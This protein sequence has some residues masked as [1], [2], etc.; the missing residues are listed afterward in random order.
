VCVEAGQADL[1]LSGYLG[2]DFQTR[3][4]AVYRLLDAV[5][6]FHRGLP[7]VGETIV[8]DIHIDKFVKQGDSW[9]FHFWFDGTV[10]G[11]P[12]IT[13]RNGVAGF[14]TAEALAAGKGIIQTTLDKQRMSG[15]KQADWTELVPQARC[16]LKPAQV[17]ALRA[18]DL[19]SAFGPA[20]ARANV[21]RPATIPGG[22]LRLVDRVPLIDPHGGRFGIGFVRA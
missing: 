7:V 4:L 10:N 13:M 14:F 11:E 3:G 5:V 20:F 15:K 17:D 19:P 8:Y 1:F 9:L 16:S 21:S 6:S 22:M 2:I 18:G 12:L